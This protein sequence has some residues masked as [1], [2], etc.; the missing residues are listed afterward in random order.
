MVNCG[1]GGKMKKKDTRCQYC[2]NSNEDLLTSEQLNKEVDK[3]LRS[4][5]F[6]TIHEKLMKWFKNMRWKNRSK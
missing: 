1:D 3:I 4:E 5:K 2:G 6:K